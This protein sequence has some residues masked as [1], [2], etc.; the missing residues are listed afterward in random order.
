M[1]R[2]SVYTCF[3]L[4]ISFVGMAQN[5][6]EKLSEGADS[7]K[8]GGGEHVKKF[9]ALPI[10]SAAPETSL[11]IGAVGVWLLRKHDVAEET[12]LSSI[13]VPIS[14]TVNNQFTAKLGATY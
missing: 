13:R 11:R 6:L 2:I 14:Y 4:M 7:L 5:P 8:S 1:Q 3:L 9:Y 12:Q 10:I